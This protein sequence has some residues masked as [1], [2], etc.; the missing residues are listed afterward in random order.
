MPVIQRFK[1]AESISGGASTAQ[2]TETGSAVARS[3]SA[4]GG[5]AANFANKLLAERKEH[6]ARTFSQKKVAQKSL[7]R[8]ELFRDLSR[9]IDP[10]DGT[11]N[12]EGSQ[13]HGMELASAMDGWEKERT[14]SLSDESPTN[15]AKRYFELSENPRM[16]KSAIESDRYQNNI[17]VKNREIIDNEIDDTQA[18][19]TLS[20][21]VD[22]EKHSDFATGEIEDM[23]RRYDESR[24]YTPLAK[25]SYK[26]K[27]GGK[28]ANAA[29]R[30]MLID[31][32]FKDA[33]DSIEMTKLMHQNPK[34][35]NEII[36]E[37]SK[38]G[39]NIDKTVFL[40]DG[41]MAFTGEKLG[42]GKSYY[43]PDGGIIQE[44]VVKEKRVDL[45]TIQIP[46]DHEPRDNKILEYISPDEQHLYS[47]QLSRALAR[48]LKKSNERLFS[49]HGNIVAGLTSTDEN[50][51][52]RTTNPQHQEAYKNHIK[53][54]IEAPISDEKKRSL[55][56]ET[57]GASEV[58]KI[59]DKYRM[60][61][62]EAAKQHRAQIGP[63][64]REAFRKLGLEDT[65]RDPLFANKLIGNYDKFLE[66]E[67]AKMRVQQGNVEYLVNNDQKYKK[68]EQNKYNS[69][70][71]YKAAKEER[72][73]LYDQ[74]E[75][76]HDL[77][78]SFSDSDLMSTA[79]LLNSNIEKENLG[80]LMAAM[81]GVA[82]R[83]N[84]IGEDIYPY[85]DAL[86][87]KG[88]KAN[89]APAL[90]FNTGTTEGNL[91]QARVF[92][93]SVIEKDII[94]GYRKRTAGVKGALSVSQVQN[95]VLN[96]V[97]MESQAILNRFALGGEKKENDF[98]DMIALDVMRNTRDLSKLSEQINRSYD[99]LV[100]QNFSG[101]KRGRTSVVISNLALK[102]S[103][104]DINPKTGRSETL[105][106]VVKTYSN[107]RDIPYGANFSWENDPAIKG[108][109]DNL[110][111]VG[112]RR[113]EKM[114]ELIED[115]TFG[116]MYMV[117]NDKG[118]NF[119]VGDNGTQAF[120]T[121]SKGAPLVIPFGIAAQDPKVLE[122][123]ES[124]LKSI[125][126]FTSESIDSL[127]STLGVGN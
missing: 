31:E 32:R 61:G 84:I 111:L 95:K 117:A 93:N 43:G 7:E 36:G 63:R 39:I 115:G 72:N 67:Y 110:K 8:Q 120:L 68:L 89:I 113:Q 34:L 58:G 37:I 82:D 2:V 42:D 123:R 59:Q 1:T 51:K 47:K 125:Q 56:T 64:L 30:T 116:E 13:Y 57:I 52:L 70:A 3:L 107:P 41:T 104:Y 11:I 29:V 121:D 62:P 78:K 88:V 6:Q 60:S 100:K 99:T 77:R 126:D 80:G 15:L 53:R 28:I 86:E 21:E 119:A 38:L 103:G 46:A 48:Q 10:S 90:L 25:D 97:T 40:S 23:E 83:Q 35:R 12:D 71:D 87:Q 4:V 114:M 124:T 19:A 49:D 102:N 27:G 76:P 122:R 127:F 101:Y 44:K 69:P 33:A 96:K 106:Q 98:V 92:Q 65:I 91:A 73:S 16:E 5:E 81:K 14:T 66:N 24:I 26:K 108:T 118:F 45:E 112:D 75:V 55:L 85:L 105:E 17:I 94:E 50:V 20:H 74:M 18:K 54:I 109:L 9:T 79:T 22:K